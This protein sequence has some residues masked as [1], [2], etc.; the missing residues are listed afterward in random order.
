MRTNT[1]KR[2]GMGLVPIPA[3]VLLLQ[4]LSCRPPSGPPPPVREGLALAIVYDTSGSMADSVVN[5]SGRSEPKFQIAGRAVNS[6]Y[7]QLGAFVAGAA[8][9]TVREVQAE[10]LVLANLRARR[11][12]SMEPFRAPVFK[13]RMASF[14]KPGGGTPLGR[15][16]QMAVE[17]LMASPLSHKHILVVTDGENTEGPAP[18]DVLSDKLEAS[19][20]LGGGVQVHFVAFD[21]AAKVFDPVKNLGATVVGA[22]DETQLK[23]Q[24]DYILQKKILLEN[25]EQ[26]LK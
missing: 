22:D 16:L 4:V 24:L 3:L 23:D 14:N 19:H 1:V 20:G 5:A 6:I 11:A 2:L 12:I 15:A 10:L 13:E 8:P 18:E 9:G 7:D 26:P 21:V 25:E 17:D